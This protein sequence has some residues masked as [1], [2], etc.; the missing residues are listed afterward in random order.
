MGTATRTSESSAFGAGSSARSRTSACSASFPSTSPPWMF[1]CTYTTTRPLAPAGRAPD[2]AHVQRRTQGYERVEE[3]P[4][5][6]VGG[7][8]AVVVAL[9]AGA[10]AADDG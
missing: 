5:V 6:G 1:A 9:R 8:L 10:R 3:A 7:G 2:G 4:D